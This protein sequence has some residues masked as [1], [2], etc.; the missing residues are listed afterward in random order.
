ME[1]RMSPQQLLSLGWESH[2]HHAVS[3]Q[4]QWHT[5]VSKYRRYVPHTMVTII[6]KPPLKKEAFFMLVGFAYR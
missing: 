5:Q 2:C 4:R 3:I 1:L 6:T